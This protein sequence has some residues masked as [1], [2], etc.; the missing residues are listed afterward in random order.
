MKQKIAP[1][2][3]RTRGISMASRYFTTKPMAHPMIST[4]FTSPTSCTPNSKHHLHAHITNITTNIR[5]HTQQQTNY[6]YT[7]D[8]H[9]TYVSHAHTHIWTHVYLWHHYDVWPKPGHTFTR[10]R[11]PLSTISIQYDVCTRLMDQLSCIW[12]CYVDINSHM[13]SKTPIHIAKQAY[14]HTCCS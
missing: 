2:G 11:T 9:D 8:S 13:Q 4:V 1:S 14:R 7:H 10:K 5:T 3:N 12:I 6:T